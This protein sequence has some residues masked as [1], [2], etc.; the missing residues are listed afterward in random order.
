MTEMQLPCSFCFRYIVRRVNQLF[1]LFL[2]ILV[3][4]VLARWLTTSIRINVV[5]MAWLRLE[6][7]VLH[8]NLVDL[9]ATA[10]VHVFIFVLTLLLL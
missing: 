5:K 7:N 8:F 1:E 6:R 10:T 3:Q 9:S 4:I 2:S